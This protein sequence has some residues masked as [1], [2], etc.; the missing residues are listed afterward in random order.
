MRARLPESSVVSCRSA[1]F[2]SSGSRILPPSRGPEPGTGNGRPHH[3]PRIHSRLTPYSRLPPCRRWPRFMNR[4]VVAL[5]SSKRQKGAPTIHP[6]LDLRT[7]D[8]NHVVLN[9]A[10]RHD[11]LNIVDASIRTGTMQ[12][13]LGGSRCSSAAVNLQRHFKHLQPAR[14]AFL[15]W[16]SPAGSPCTFRWTPAAPSAAPSAPTATQRAPSRRR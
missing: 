10:E 9:L 14:V 8:S 15:T 4:P 11:G 12:K 7:D 16:G 1:S 6:I 5:S 13:Y 2:G 3:Q